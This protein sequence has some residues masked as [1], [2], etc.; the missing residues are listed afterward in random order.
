MSHAVDGWVSSGQMWWGQV[1]YVVLYEL[2][3]C[4]LSI[5][6]RLLSRGGKCGEGLFQQFLHMSV[7]IAI[8]LFVFISLPS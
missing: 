5:V 7:F 6:A 2:Q 3:Y 8:Q 1:S 4:E